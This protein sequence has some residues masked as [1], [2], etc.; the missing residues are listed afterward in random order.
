MIVLIIVTLHCIFSSNLVWFLGVGQLFEPDG[1]STS[2]YE[3][4]LSVDSLGLMFLEF[5]W[6]E[7]ILLYHKK[8][9]PITHFTEAGLYL[10]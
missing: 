4:L 6:I 7:T 10:F 1:K 3:L 8:S 9:L 5:K 2:Y